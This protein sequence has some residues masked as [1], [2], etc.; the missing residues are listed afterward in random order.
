MQISNPLSEPLKNPHKL[1]Q[2]IQ[3][4]VKLI[5]GVLL[6]LFANA[7]CVSQ[8]V[9]QPAS[10]LVLAV[11]QPDE[12]WLAQVPALLQPGLGAT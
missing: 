9:L 4:S 6:G 11:L 3:K 12:Y 8:G 1:C 5:K 7:R 2:L 10:M